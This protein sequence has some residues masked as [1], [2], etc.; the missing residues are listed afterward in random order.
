MKLIPYEFGFTKVFDSIE[1]LNYNLLNALEFSVLPNGMIISPLAKQPIQFG[2][3]VIIASI[4][5]N[6]IHYAGEGEIVFD[7]IKNLKMVVTLFGLYL[8]KMRVLDDRD[9][10]S[11]YM[12]EQHDENQINHVNITVQFIDNSRIS[13]NYYINKC[14]PYV[15]LMFKLAEE[16]VSITNFDITVEEYL[17]RRGN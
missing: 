4:D 11:Y 9:I 15:D 1:E 12:D 10:L 8:D 17:A 3:K 2:G 16:D 7:V 6:N 13:S 5:Q 14:L